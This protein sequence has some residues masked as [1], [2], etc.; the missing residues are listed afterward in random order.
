MV[1]GQNGNEVNLDILSLPLGG[2]PSF[3]PLPINTS[4]F[5][6][7]S[8]SLEQQAILMGSQTEQTYDDSDSD[9]D[10]TDNYNEVVET[11]ITNDLACMSSRKP[12]RAI[13]QRPQRNRPSEQFL[14][15]F[16]YDD[17]DS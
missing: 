7:K 16:E 9:T 14:K 6:T 2:Q 1:C 12:D 10:L 15:Q 11:D 13:K 4:E 8:E 3:T 17:L 5:K